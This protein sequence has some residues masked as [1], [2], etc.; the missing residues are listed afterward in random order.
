MKIKTAGNQVQM[1][2][3]HWRRHHQAVVKNVML[4]FVKVWLKYEY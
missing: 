2:P 4:K 3:P 1:R